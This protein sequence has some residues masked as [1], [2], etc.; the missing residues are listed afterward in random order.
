[1]KPRT[2]QSW[3][4]AGYQALSNL[5]IVWKFFSISSR[6]WF[7]FFKNVTIRNILE[8][9]F[10]CSDALLFPSSSVYSGWCVV[11]WC[12]VKKVN[13]T[14]ENKCEKTKK[15]SRI[16]WRRTDELR[17]DVVIQPLSRDETYFLC[18]ELLFQIF[19]F[20]TTIGIEWWTLN[21]H[22]NWKSTKLYAW[23]VKR[24]E[25]WK[26]Q[27][28]RNS[29]RTD[30]DLFHSMFQICKLIFFFVYKKYE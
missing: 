21:T 8:K 16:W 18:Y 6:C 23:N 29:H 26:F 13:T 25:I 4:A 9:I 22:V 24:W 30:I 11:W 15:K 5:I 1:M 2:F 10:V 3:N 17:A 20:A 7:K 19:H 12:R 27:N 28:L 14:R